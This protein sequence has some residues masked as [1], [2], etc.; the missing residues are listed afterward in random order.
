MTGTWAR[1][2][3]PFTDRRAAEIDQAADDWLA[4]IRPTTPAEPRP[5]DQTKS[6]DR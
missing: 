6:E 5:Y 4:P 1:L 2:L 3:A